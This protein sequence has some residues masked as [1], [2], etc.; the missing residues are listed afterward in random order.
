SATPELRSGSEAHRGAGLLVGVVAAAVG[1]G[2]DEGGV[3][4]AVGE[5]AVVLGLAPGG[6]DV[7]AQLVD[8]F[9]HLV[10]VRFG[11]A[12]VAT[13]RAGGACVADRATSKVLGV[14]RDAGLAELGGGHRLVG[15]VV[16]V[17]VGKGGPVM[18]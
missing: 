7:L 4:V 16:T 6:F 3:G 2:V 11:H 12:R 10:G 17:G 15:S 1:V 9:L 18:R 8:P 13:R 14:D 5:E